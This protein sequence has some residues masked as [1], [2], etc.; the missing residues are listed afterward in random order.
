ME[1]ITRHR[2]NKL[3]QKSTFA[4]IK[5]KLKK[6]IKFSNWLNI[7]KKELK[8]ITSV[9]VVFIYEQ[10]GA[11]W[12]IYNCELSNKIKIYSSVWSFYLDF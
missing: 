9:A 1:E 4:L 3:F 10:L 11:C 5:T 12:I 8:D 7:E 2:E 6:W